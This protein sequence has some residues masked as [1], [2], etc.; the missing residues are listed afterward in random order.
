MNALRRS[1]VALVCVLAMVGVLAA[2][3]AAQP[4][5]A[6]VW[7]CRPGIPNDP[8][9]PDFTITRYNAHGHV[10]AVK[11]EPNKYTKID[12][13]YVYPTTSDQVGPQANFDI[14][15]ELRSIAR[16][17]AW[18]Y[19]S[20]CRVFAP[21][22]RQIT[23]LGLFNPATTPAMRET[24]YQDVRN[25]WLDYLAHDNVGRGV[26]FIGH[27]QGAGILRRLIREEVDPKPAVRD[28]LVSA[29][30]LGG[31]V[32]VQ[33][34]RDIGGDF[35]NVPACRSRSQIGCVIAF[36]TFGEP[37]P[38]GSFFGRSSN[39]DLEVLCTNPASLRGGS[40]EV[41]PSQPT[42]PF[43]PGSIIGSVIGGLGTPPITA[44]TDFV[45]YRN[46]YRARCTSDGGANVLQV[47]PLGTSP[48]L[49]P[50][51]DATWGLHLADAN[52]ALGDLVKLVHRE[53][54]RWVA[55]HR[56]RSAWHRAHALGHFFG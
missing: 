49:H 29:I 46:G 3:A 33:K 15:P 5:A 26:V 55:K 35:Q 37:V 8:C 23:V 54:H 16:Y 32:T 39:P 36:S 56:V 30:L 2:P 14:G 41:T 45:E 51:P 28:L 13:F 25:A 7:L 11:H 19:A 22:Y 4:A 53:A 43:A 40:G 52:I 44:T 18:R 9:A 24:A 47:T 20:E 17:Q 38:A 27:S 31:N 6:T 50:V 48:F 10:S 1:F 42:E 21:V 34:G 12:C